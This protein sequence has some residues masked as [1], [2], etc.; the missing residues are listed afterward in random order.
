MMSDSAKAAE[1]PPGLRKTLV[2]CGLFLALDIFF[3]GAPMLGVYAG[4]A[5]V[6]WLIP[7]IFVA[8]KRPDL[9]RHRARVALVI[10]AVLAADCGA[11]LASEIV[12]EKRVVEVAD[13]MAR[14]KAE[15]SAY[16]LR[17]QDLVPAYL[18]AIP[19]AKPVSMMAGGPIY[20]FDPNLPML[21]YVSIPPF[22]RRVLNVVTREWT[23]LD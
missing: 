6:L 3:V 2:F 7:R 17:L 18:P 5:L 8:W 1:K 14:Y 13:A 10:A 12:A 4:L 22:G 16:P 15:R 11:Y 9:R 20:L 21:M 23:D 19:A